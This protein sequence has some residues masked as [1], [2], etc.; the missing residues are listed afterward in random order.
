MCLHT[1]NVDDFWEVYLTF[2]QMPNPHPFD[3]CRRFETKPTSQASVMI[4]WCSLMKNTSYVYLISHILLKNKVISIQACAHIGTKHVP[5]PALWQWLRS[6]C[7]CRQPTE[8]FPVQTAQMLRWQSCYRRT[9]THTHTRNTER[10]K[11]TRW[12]AQEQ[13]LWLVIERG[14]CSSPVLGIQSDLHTGVH[15]WG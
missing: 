4:M 3:F 5:R 12:G 11:W 13:I 15:T 7:Y 6:A 9:H 2:T 1:N 14:C 8:G 10:R